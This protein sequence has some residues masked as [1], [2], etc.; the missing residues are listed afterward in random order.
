MDWAFLILVTLAL[1]ATPFALTFWTSYYTPTIGLSCRSFT[2]LLYFCFQIWLSMTWLWD[3]HRENRHSFLQEVTWPLSSDKTIYIPSFYC[4]VMAFGPTGSI[5]TAIAGTSLQIIGGY[6]NC[7]CSIPIWDWASR[8]NSPV[9]L[10]SNT[11]DAIMLA[12]SF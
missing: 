4:V 6:R 11:A 3:F 2:F 1:M 9:V 7:L 5:F 10:S 12:N 8:D